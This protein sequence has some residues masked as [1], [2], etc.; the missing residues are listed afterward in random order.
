MN[1]LRSGMSAVALAAVGVGLAGCH[2]AGQ[3]ATSSVAGKPAAVAAAPGK[4]AGGCGL[5]SPAAVG[6]AL[7]M[8]MEA[9]DVTNDPPITVCDYWSTNRHKVIIRIQRDLGPKDFSENKASMRTEL[10]Q[11]TIDVPGIGDEAYVTSNH[12]KFVPNNTLV[13]RKGAVE[14]MISSGATVNRE[15]SLMRTLFAGL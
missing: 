3:A 2:S 15:K 12:S 5:A 1:V 9:P 10:N 14:I 4:G 13:A 6:A 8:T 11:P 7:G